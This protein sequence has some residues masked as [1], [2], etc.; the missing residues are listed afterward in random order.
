MS[1]PQF[2]VWTYLLVGWGEPLPGSTEKGADAFASYAA[3]KILAERAVWKFSDE[4]P[5]ANI[6]THVYISF[7]FFRDIQSPPLKPVVLPGFIL[8]PEE[9]DP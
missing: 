6:V 2:F 3:S 9:I 1:P 4:H 5:N 8:G 7:T